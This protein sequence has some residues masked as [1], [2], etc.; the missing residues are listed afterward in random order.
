[1]NK[2]LRIKYLLE[3]Y[4]KNSGTVKEKSELACFLSETD[5]K[6]LTKI[7][8]DFWEGQ[9]ETDSVLSKR[10]QERIILN[11]LNKEF[12]KKVDSRLKI[13]R[14]VKIAAASIIFLLSIMGTFAYVFEKDE[15]YLK[16]VTAKETIEKVLLPDGSLI[17]LKPYSTITYP[18]EFRDNSREIAFDGEA[19]FEIAKNPDIPFVVRSNGITTRVLGT[20]FNIKSRG[21]QTEIFVLTGK[22]EVTS[23]KTQ[24][25]LELIP[26]E[27]AIYIHRTLDLE[28]V[29][30][31]EN[32]EKEVF[33]EGTEYKM[34]FD[35]ENLKKIAKKIE[36]KFNV[37]IRI[38]NGLDFTLLTA[39]L[40]GQSLESSLDILTSAV[41]ASYK[42]NDN[43]IIIK[44]RRTW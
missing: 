26:D 9:N 39:D 22:V 21:D 43:E 34:K 28:K 35:D 23:A 31:I 8:N 5:D 44:K 3:K 41:N 27:K 24:E 30:P 19:L 16:I 14:W 15:V 33:I 12:N 10:E 40:T 37:K 18:S 4:I 11:I 42:I 38:L 6:T 20:S 32:K 13:V 29:L 36:D 1:M 7:L 2:T 17:W 25:K